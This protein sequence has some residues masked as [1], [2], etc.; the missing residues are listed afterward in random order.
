MG[1]KIAGRVQPRR[2]GLYTTTI[3]YSFFRINISI[4]E[5]FVPFQNQL[6]TEVGICSIVKDKHP[7]FTLTGVVS[8][9]FFVNSTAHTHTERRGGD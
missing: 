3:S 4:S 2:T 7:K 8:C 1:Y 9:K 6:L 5:I